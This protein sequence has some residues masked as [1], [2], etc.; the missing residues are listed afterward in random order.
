V[1]PGETLGAIVKAYRDQNIK[2]SLQQI[3][4]AN[5]GLKPENLKAGQKII[6]PAPA[7]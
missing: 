1:K 3:L 4:A 5:P 2:V 6:I 7:Q